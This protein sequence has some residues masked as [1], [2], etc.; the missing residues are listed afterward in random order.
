MHFTEINFVILK[1]R[2]V[3]RLVRHRTGIEKGQ[4]LY[5]ICGNIS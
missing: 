1:S 4:Y 3:D 2:N 5:N